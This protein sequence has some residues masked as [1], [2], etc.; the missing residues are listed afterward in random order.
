MK[1]SINQLIADCASDFM[2]AHPELVQKYSEAL[3]NLMTD[4]ERSYAMLGLEF[5]IRF[6]VETI[7]MAKKT[8]KEEK[9][10]FD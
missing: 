3:S 6:M 5:A 2:K 7:A 10:T 1:L 4:K 8:A 9:T